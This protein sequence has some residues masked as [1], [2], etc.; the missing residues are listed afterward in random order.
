[1]R[2]EK[3]VNSNKSRIF[4]PILVERVSPLVYFCNLFEYVVPEAIVIISQ[5]MEG[6]KAIINVVTHIK[7][8]SK[9]RKQNNSLVT[10]NK[11]RT[12]LMSAQTVLEVGGLGMT[13]RVGGLSTS[14]SLVP[15]SKNT[16]VKIISI[17]ERK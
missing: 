16:K 10:D 11:R 14:G 3:I 5:A 9:M 4:A 8:I 12:I 15:S 2:G 6:I 17:R 7:K 1:M 13:F